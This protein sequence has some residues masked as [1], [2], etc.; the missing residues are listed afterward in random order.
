MAMTMCGLIQSILVRV[1]VT[2]IRFSMSKI[3]EGEWWADKDAIAPTV[4]TAQQ[5]AEIWCFKMA[6]P[7][8]VRADYSV[9]ANERSRNLVQGL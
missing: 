6:L 2:A 1:P 3:A 8:N 5:T 4:K 9:L 7:S